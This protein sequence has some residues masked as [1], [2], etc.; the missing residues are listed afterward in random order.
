[1]GANA[2]KDK[3]RKEDVELLKDINNRLTKE[4]IEKYRTFWYQ[5]YPSG[6]MTKEGFSSFVKKAFPNWDQSKGS[7]DHLFRAMDQDKSGIVTFKEFLMF[8]SL[9]APT[10]TTQSNPLD[11][12]DL[13]FSMYDEDGDGFITINELRD[14]LTNI[15]KTQGIDVS[16][17]KVK[18]QIEQRVNNLVKAIDSDSDGKLTKQEITDACTKNPNLLK[19]L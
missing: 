11:T 13:V 5:L 8:Q 2:S 18:E 17:D 10:N 7:Y 9:T 16:L 1:M 4:D 12:I 6:E 14:S 19:F 15:Y 3:L